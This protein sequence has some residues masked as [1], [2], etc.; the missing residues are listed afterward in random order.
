MSEAVRREIE[1]QQAR[2]E[3]GADG[4]GRWVLAMARDLPHPP[5]RVWPRLTDPE[6]LAGWSPVVPDR[7]LDS[8]GPARSRE[9]PEDTWLDAEVLVS[10]APHELVHR[11]GADLLR[12]TL[13]PTAGGCRLTL[14][15]TF[16]DRDGTAMYAA[17]WHICLASLATRL[18]GDESPRIAGAAAHDYGWA[19]LRDAYQN[20]GLIIRPSAA[21]V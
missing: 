18:D 4:D 15:H 10:D 9:N 8:P 2:A 5:G 3:L 13:T 17:G 12:W 7:R 19:G 20:G 21:E 16:A 11:W 6:L 14:E 1:R